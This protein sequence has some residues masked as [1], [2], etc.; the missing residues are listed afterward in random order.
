MSAKKEKA[1]TKLAS[2]TYDIDDGQEELSVDPIQ[3]NTTL[4]TFRPTVKKA[5][6]HVLRELAIYIKRLK[7]K[8]SVIAD[9]KKTRIGK[10]ILG[11]LSELR[12]LKKM[13]TIRLC[14]LLLANISTP[15]EVS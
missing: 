14:K 12:L 15:E 9:S 13:N 7:Q 11:R 3:L 4:L 10:K 2:L 1:A 5:R 8:Q 6:L